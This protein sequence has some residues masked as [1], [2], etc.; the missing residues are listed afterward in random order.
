MNRF[1]FGRYN[2]GEVSGVNL[3]RRVFLS[4]IFGESP[5]PYKWQ[6]VKAGNSALRVSMLHV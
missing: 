6:G 5:I 1:D 3:W 2:Q 4:V